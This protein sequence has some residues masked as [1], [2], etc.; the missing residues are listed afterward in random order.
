MSSDGNGRL[1][2]CRWRQIIWQCLLSPLPLLLSTVLFEKDLSGKQFHFVLKRWYCIPS[3]L[4]PRPPPPVRDVVDQRPHG[5][6]LVQ[7]GGQAGRHRRQQAQGDEGVKVG[8]VRLP[9]KCIR[10]K[11][12]SI[13]AEHEPCSTSMLDLSNRSSSSIFFF[14]NR[15]LE[16][17]QIRSPN[18]RPRHHLNT[19]WVE[20]S[21]IATSFLHCL[22]IPRERWV[23]LHFNTR[24]GFDVNIFQTFKFD[25]QIKIFDKVNMAFKGL[26]WQQSGIIGKCR[27]CRNLEN[28]SQ[29]KIRWPFRY[30]F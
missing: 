9:K 25:S 18:F 4:F 21:L 15:T 19:I 16:M 28:R 7:H 10:K 22:R 14:G 12:S 13:D 29:I 20:M 23:Q 2:T 8:R 17:R 1:E 6:R 3:S 24:V 30:Y 27:L 26:L 11:W 5:G